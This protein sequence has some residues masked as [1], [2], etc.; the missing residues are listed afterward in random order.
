[1]TDRCRYTLFSTI[2]ECYHTA[3]AERKL[4]F[5]LA[6]LTCN[7]AGYRAVYLVC[8]PILAGN[9]L[10]AQNIG[11]VLLYFFCII[12]GILIMALYRFVDHICLW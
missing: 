6:L 8:E 4:N 10:K 12:L 11:E 1:M 5:A 3:V 7:L 2:V 9:S